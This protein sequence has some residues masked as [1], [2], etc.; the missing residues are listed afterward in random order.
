MYRFMTFMLIFGAMSS[1]CTIMP[2][3]PSENKLALSEPDTV[4][5]IKI[6][7][8]LPGKVKKMGG[9]FIYVSPR[10]EIKTSKN[11]CLIRGGEI[12]R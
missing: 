2:P 1:A 5:G 9:S 7:C 3:Q 10:R 4:R 8:L 12:V 6:A 11:D